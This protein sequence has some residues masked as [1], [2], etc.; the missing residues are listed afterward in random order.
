MRT[1]FTEGRS[2]YY[3]EYDNTTNLSLKKLEN[4]IKEAD[5]ELANKNYDI[6]ISLFKEC[7]INDYPKSIPLN[8]RIQKSI[9]NAE[10]QK[11]AYQRKLEQERIAEE[12]KQEKLRLAE[13]KKQELIRL[14]EEKKRKK[15]EQDNSPISYERVF[16]RRSSSNSNS[17]S[18]TNNNYYNSSQS[19]E[20]F[21]EGKIYKNSS[22]G[23]TLKYGYITSL[24]TYGITLRTSEGSVAYAI[25]C[26]QQ[27]SSDN[28]FM[29][30]TFCL[31]ITT[32]SEFGELSVY[33]DRMIWNA[34]GEYNTFYLEN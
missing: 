16:G 6:A 30:L 25:N 24:G 5:K 32:G 33:K 18:N 11:I 14:A 19:V 31:N 26:T 23:A 15:T 21:V 28:Q 4:R 3:Y 9:Q 12:K 7:G 13:E 1:D 34:G 20:D 17:N 22:L 10:S 27:N 2:Y 29:K 8:L